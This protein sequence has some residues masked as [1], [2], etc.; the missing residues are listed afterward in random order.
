MAHVNRLEEVLPP[1]ESLPNLEVKQV[2]WL[3]SGCPIVTLEH[4]QHF[5]SKRMSRHMTVHNKKK[6]TCKT[7]K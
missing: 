5:I 6:N 3:R 4:L 7:M 2:K 1:F